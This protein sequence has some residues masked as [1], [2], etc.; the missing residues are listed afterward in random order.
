MKFNLDLTDRKADDFDRLDA[1]RR[2]EAG[3]YKCV[4]DDASENSQ[5]GQFTFE[6]KVLAAAAP[7]N[8][9]YV[10]AVIFDNVGNPETADSDKAAEMTLRRVGL[11]GKRLGLI[12][13]ENMGQHFDLDFADAINTEAVVHVEHRS[14][15]DR[16]GSQREIDS[17]K[18]D[19]VYP[20][21]HPKIPADVRAALGLPALANAAP[22]TTAAGEKPARQR[23]ETAARAANGPPATP[24][25]PVDVSDL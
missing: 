23:R 3:W 21:N 11:L 2:P 13:P 8:A 14:Y 25:P 22:A 10:G 12:K 18:F 19:G 1:N 5:T 6:W 16:D 4:L 15:K 17:V 20:L 24:R 9:V 7:A